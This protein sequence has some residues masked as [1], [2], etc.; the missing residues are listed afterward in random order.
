MKALP[1]IKIAGKT[2]Y[3]DARLNELRNVSNPHD[4][5]KM[6]GSAEFYIQ[7]FKIK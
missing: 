6:E 5:E 3:V 1:K 7:H 4:I 2:Y